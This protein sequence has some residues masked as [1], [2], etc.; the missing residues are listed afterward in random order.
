MN[1][2][3]LGRVIEILGKERGIDRK[4]VISAIEHAFLVTAR[5]KFGI[6]GEYETRYNEEDD[7]IEIYQ[8][9]NVVA[10]GESNDEILEIGFSKARELDEECEVGDQLGL[11][12]EDPS[13]SRVDIQS[14]KQVIFQ[15]IRDAERGNSL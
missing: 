6:Q 15:K 10:D 9:K 13:F 1:F 14:V 2:S 12:V 3:E 11:R 4:I 8:Y 5:K 7:N